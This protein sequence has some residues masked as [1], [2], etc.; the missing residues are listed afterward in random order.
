MEVT[1]MPDFNELQDRPLFM[2][3]DSEAFNKFAQVATYQEYQP[4][5][6]IIKEG[7][8]KDTLMVIENGQVEVLKGDLSLYAD[9]QKIATVS[10]D[11][12]FCDIFRGDILGE[13]S[14]I[15]VEP[16]SA[17]V[18]AVTQAGIWSIDR[19]DFAAVLR[20]DLTTYIVV[21][22]NIARILSRRLRDAGKIHL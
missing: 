22:T 14:L 20:K 7:E 3:V 18:R 16:A 6:V 1:I 8:Q 2:G 19:V 11:R 13:M 4:G 12:K 21:I 15:D 9:D 17:T 10:G 5:E